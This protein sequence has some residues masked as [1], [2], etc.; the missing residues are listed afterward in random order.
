ELSAAVNTTYS[1]Y[2]ATLT[3]RLKLIDLFLVFLVALGILQ[4]VY[5]L[6]VGNFPFNAFLGGFISCVGQFVLT[7][8]LR[9]Q[10]KSATNAE[11]AFGDFVFASL[12]LHFVVYHFIN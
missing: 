10:I 1:D 6:L 4:F 8:S 9:L 3:P 7:V 12:I 11:R 2:V 5:V